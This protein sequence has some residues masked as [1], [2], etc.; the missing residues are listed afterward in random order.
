MY[1]RKAS[2]LTDWLHAFDEYSNSSINYWKLKPDYALLISIGKKMDLSVQEGE[3][4]G[5]PV[6]DVSR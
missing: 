6:R 5:A 2:E 3:K 1:S 4:F